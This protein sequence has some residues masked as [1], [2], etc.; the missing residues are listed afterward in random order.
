VYAKR[1]ICGQIGTVDKPCQTAW[2]SSGH[3]ELPWPI[4]G[5]EAV[6]AGLLTVR[7]LRRFYVPVYPDVHVLRGVELS[8]AQ[9]ARAAWLWSRRRGVIAD[10]SAAAMLGC[11]W[12]EPGLPAE[13]V[14]RNRR[15][16]PMLMVHSD[17]VDAGEVQLVNGMAVT[18]AART[19][20]D[21]GRR[22]A[23]EPGVRRVDALMNATDVKVSDIES[24]ADR[25]PGVRGLAQL[26]RTLKLV[27]GGAESPYESLT[28]L[29]FVRVGFPPPET[30][31]PVCDEYG[32]L[33]AVI[34]MGWRDY[35]VGI[36]FD[37]AHHWTNPRQRRWDAAAA[38]C[39]RNRTVDG[40]DRRS[41]VRPSWRGPR[42]PAPTRSI[43]R[44]P[45]P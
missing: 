28:R 1:R 21:I 37:D 2:A 40:R 18:T 31:I 24:V 6:D 19:A 11:K 16:P 9:R 22:V 14:H 17:D 30:Q 10:L 27:D 3:D 7:E 41:K 20:F 45:R 35:L 8:A 5:R 12:I 4:R 23:P 25:H 26:R 29:L 42:A 36:D 38:C 15:Q 44:S 43:P 32:V 34:D 33:I 13:L 39:V